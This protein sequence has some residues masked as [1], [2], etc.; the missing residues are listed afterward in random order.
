MHLYTS[1]S[2]RPQTL[3]YIIGLLAALVAGQTILQWGAT[4]V[5]RKYGKNEIRWAEERQGAN[6]LKHDGKSVLLIGSSVLFGV[7]PVRLQ[8]QMPEWTV[9]RTVMVGTFYTDWEYSLKR[10]FREG[11]QPDYVVLVPLPFQIFGDSFRGDSLPLHW[12]DRRDILDL[13]RKKNLDMTS[14]SNLL[15]ASYNSFFAFRDDVRNAFLGNLIPGHKVLAGGAVSMR[16]YKDGET[17]QI[18]ADRLVA[19]QL[20]VT[21]H[22]ARLA[23][24]RYPAPDMEASLDMMKR[25]AEANRIPYFSA[26]DA[27][28]KAEFED[29]Y[30]LNPRGTEKFTDALAPALKEELTR[31][32]AAPQGGH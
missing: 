27:I 25:I 30:H 12:V 17:E 26:L 21:G 4:W 19:L 23:V 11:V 2:E 1:N 7:D 14:T 16:V 29:A 22:G 31:L 6:A 5:M 24:L 13:A 18:L 20:L 10:M 15:F 32:R 3:K 9:R 8:K 28:P